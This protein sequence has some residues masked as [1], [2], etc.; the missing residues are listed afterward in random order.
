MGL[1]QTGF[2]TDVF[3]TILGLLTLLS[4]FEIIYAE[5][6]RSTLV[7]GLLATVT[8]GLSLIGAYLLLSPEIE[9]NE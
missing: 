4:G 8:L 6:E 9:G 2:R 1:L 7:A 3:S 5:I